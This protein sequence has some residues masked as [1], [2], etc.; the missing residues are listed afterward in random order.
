MFN[1]NSS[2]DDVSISSSVDLDT[3]DDELKRCDSENERAKTQSNVLVNKSDV[4][5]DSYH[6]SCS[7]DVFV[8]KGGEEIHKSAHDDDE[9]RE[10]Y[11]ESSENK[12]NVSLMKW[13]EFPYHAVMADR[14]DV[15]DIC[16]KISY[17]MTVFRDEHKT[18]LL[19]A[20]V[21]KV[22]VNINIIEKLL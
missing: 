5:E 17:D 3:S 10:L 21:S 12:Y 1:D 14:L 8:H 19:H 20:A 13:L 16:I 2:S 18:T 6:P 11:T 4:S 7:D 9:S 15:F 22:S